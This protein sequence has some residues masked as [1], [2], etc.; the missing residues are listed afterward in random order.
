M[1]SIVGK[2]LS[3]EDRVFAIRGKKRVRHRLK[4][5]LDSRA[6][7]NL[8]RILLAASLFMFQILLLC[9]VLMSLGVAPLTLG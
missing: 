3:K 1:Y 6:R 7:K 2:S 8:R 5:H 4:K 9:S